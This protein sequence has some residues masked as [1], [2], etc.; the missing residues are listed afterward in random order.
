MKQI[1]SIDHIEEKDPKMFA[2]QMLHISSEQVNPVYKKEKKWM[3]SFILFFTKVSTNGTATAWFSIFWV[4]TFIVALFSVLIF[5]APAIIHF[6]NDI[7]HVED[8]RIAS[9]IGPGMALMFLGVYATAVR[10]NWLVR[11]FVD[12]RTMGFSLRENKSIPVKIIVSK[13]LI[14]KDIHTSMVVESVKNYKDS[15]WTI[16]EYIARPFFLTGGNEQE[17]MRKGIFTIFITGAILFSTFSLF[18]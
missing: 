7:Q 17:I 11:L 10:E 9:I 3:P 6:K 13:Y 2:I 14:E 5:V 4:I 8:I 18:L 16:W 12:A 15:M 1:C